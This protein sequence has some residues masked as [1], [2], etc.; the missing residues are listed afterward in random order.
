M[1][2]PECK[3]AGERSTVQDLGGSVTLLGWSPY[4]D[5]DGIRHAHDPN[6]HN[7]QYRCSRGHVW[8][9]SYYPRCANCDY[10]KPEEAFDDDE[11][12]P[13]RRCGAFRVATG[14]VCTQESDHD[15]KCTFASDSAP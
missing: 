2:C 4:W 6:C 3:K 1:K 7:N 9:E 10:G 11:G 15:G 5:E 12:R 13:Y 8:A 14:E